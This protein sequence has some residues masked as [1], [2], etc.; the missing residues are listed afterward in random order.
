MAAKNKKT[1]KIDEGALL[2]GIR[3]RIQEQEINLAATASEIIDAEDA[4]K[5]AT[6]A[7]AESLAGAPFVAAAVHKV[8]GAAADLARDIQAVRGGSLDAAKQ[9]VTRIVKVGR[10]LARFPEWDA[11]E[12]YTAT[13]RLTTAQ[14]DEMVNATTEAAAKKVM[15]EKKTTGG[16]KKKKKGPNP[17]ATQVEAFSGTAKALT[18]RTAEDATRAE[19]EKY[20][21]VLE[22]NVSRVRAMLDGGVSFS[23]E[24]KAAEAEAA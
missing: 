7:L 19:A 22:A 10:V 15:A 12:T 4:A 1:S 18:D 20:L 3:E 16:S 24:R 9:A 23:D 21:K 6:A 13:N 11:L 8:R 5:G 17:Y 2:A 14:V